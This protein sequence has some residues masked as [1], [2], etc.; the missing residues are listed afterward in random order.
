MSDDR[1]PKLPRM[2]HAPEHQYVK[3][4]AIIGMLNYFRHRL[5]SYTT[6]RERIFRSLR[7][8]QRGCYN[9]HLQL[10]SDLNFIAYQRLIG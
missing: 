10:E 9:Q 4:F 5:A 6:V 8:Q 1:T 2:Q 3:S 7:W